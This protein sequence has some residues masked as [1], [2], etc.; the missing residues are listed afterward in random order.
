[1]EKHFDR[2]RVGDRVAS[3][4]KLRGIT[5]PQL[6][7]AAHFSTSTVKQVEQGAIPPSAAFVAA[8]ARALGV[9]AAQLYGV[10]ERS[11]AEEDP[12]VLLTGLRVA[13][14]ACDDPRPEGEPLTLDAINQRL[15]LIARQVA[16]TKYTA[17][18]DDLAVLLHHLY[19]LADRSGYDGESARAALHDAYRLAATVAGRYRQMDLAAVASERHIQLAP[20]TGD[21]L[22]VAISAFHRSSSYLS[23]GD[24]ADGL[25]VLSRVDEHL[26]V[27]SQVATQVHLR[28]AILH[29]RAGNLDRADER[30]A[31]AR[32]APAVP[33]TYRGIDGSRLNVDVHWCALPVEALDGSE[34]VRRGAEI[35]LTDTSRPE[36]IGHHHIDQAR[37]W[38]LHGDRERCLAE[39]NLAR[40]TAPFNTRHH[41]A[42][43][44]T[45][46]AIADADRRATDSRAG[47]AKWA[48]IAV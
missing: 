26:A 4:R 39:L 3:L 12:G 13:I 9:T 47:F 18:A 42:V 21:P 23:H 24:Y 40:R 5:Q 44:E 35:Q 41:P 17:A 45:V 11:M 32:R 37:A 33:A 31:E 16:G 20:T 28:A 10:G 29:A 34:A 38:F 22:R 48:G 1:M 2:D 43:R 36:R 27:P 19:P 30:L 8:A 6:A 46:L 15:D 14:D 7:A 25:R